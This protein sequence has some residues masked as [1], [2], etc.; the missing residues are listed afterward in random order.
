MKLKL[1]GNGA[2]TFDLI[3]TGEGKRELVETN[4][5]RNAMACVVKDSS[6]HIEL[7]R[8]R[9]GLDSYGRTIRPTPFVTAYSGSAPDTELTR[10]LDSLGLCDY[11]YHFNLLAG[12]ITQPNHTF[13]VIVLGVRTYVVLDCA[14]K[15]TDIW[16][17]RRVN[18]LSLL[19]PND[20]DDLNL[21]GVV[22]VCGEFGYWWN[23]LSSRP[24]IICQSLVQ[25]YTTHDIASH[26]IPQ[27]QGDL[28]SG[29]LTLDK[30]GSDL[31]QKDLR[32]FEYKNDLSYESLEPVASLRAVLFLNQPQL[33]N[34]DAAT[35][36]QPI[37]KNWRSDWV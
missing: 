29:S 35:P 22:W 16:K 1:F 28:K 12:N 6:K 15:F 27:L 13:T 9:R 32:N 25:P 17:I 19:S 14:Q 23:K 34:D 24:N 18:K 37:T 2:F 36:K 10:Y 31:L 11:A 5:Q 8:E 21:S 26:L 20:I 33:L 7:I 3:H 4:D 30:N